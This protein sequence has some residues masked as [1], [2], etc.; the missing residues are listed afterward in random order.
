MDIAERSI[1]DLRVMLDSGEA[2]AEA[3]TAAYVEQIERFSRGG[4]KLNAVREV[5]PEALA[6]AAS[7]DRE[8]RSGHLRSPLHGVPILIKD[9][10]GT[11]DAMRTT[12]GAH[13]LADL[14]TPFDAGVVRRL[15]AA[16][17][18]ILGKCN[19]PDFCDYMASTMPSEHSTTG[20]T[21]GHPYGK[22]YVRGGGSS[23]GVASAVAASLAAAGVG[24]ETQNSIQAPCANTS[25]IGIK[26][27]VGLVS[28][29][30]MV[31][32]ATTQDT[33]GAIARSVRDAALL[34]SVIAGPDPDDTMTQ[35]AL[36]AMHADFS[37]YCVQTA[38]VG[39]RI[40]VA[41]REFFGR[42]GRQAIDAVVEKALVVL[43]EAGARIVDPADVPTASTVMPMVS[44]VFRTD[45]KVGLNDF[46]KRCGGASRMRSMH[47]VVLH[48]ESVGSAAIPFGQDLL[49]AADATAGDWS[50][51]L[52]H[53][54][55]AR[56]IRLTRQE[57]IDRVIALHGL[58]ALVVPM[59][60]AAKFTGKAGYPAITVPCGYVEDGAPV[61][62]TFIGPAFSEPRLIGIAYAFE[63]ATRARRPPVLAS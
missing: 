12:G 44:R 4:L 15:R 34:L 25:L 21:I 33:A 59:D 63:Q 5:N 22:R 6:I 60:H 32:L 28:R 20:G 48:N 35:S 27:T 9:N 39:A 58:D 51:P 45:F 50:E 38:L 17:A 14:R 40:G 13:A 11:V 31:P 61:G 16:G 26:P 57:G 52:Y 56:D 2:S 53:I 42:D 29:A 10:I 43:H 46:L 3:L 30:G 37:R 47:D 41:R 1:A 49:L 19:C 54:D 36:G 7:L 55:R 8:M 18:V 23:T 62:L 24:S